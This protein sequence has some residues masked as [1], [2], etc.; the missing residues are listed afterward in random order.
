M[1]IYN[2]LE[3]PILMDPTLYIEMRAER[4]FILIHCFFLL[5]F[6]YLFWRFAY[7]TGIIAL[8]PVSLSL[9]LLL[10]EF[11]GHSQSSSGYLLNNSRSAS[12]Q[13]DITHF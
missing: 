7:S 10:L 11:G 5:F 12:V 6:P 3:L 4:V 8:L 13:I 1:K 2:I 9:F